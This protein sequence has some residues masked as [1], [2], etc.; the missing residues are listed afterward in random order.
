MLLP[1]TSVR[2]KSAPTTNTNIPPSVK[3][4]RKPKPSKL[5]LRSST[6]GL[7]FTGWMV[8]DMVAVL[9]K[10]SPSN[11]CSCT[12]RFPTAGSSAVFPNSSSD[13]TLV[14]VLTE[15]LP[16]ILINCAEANN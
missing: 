13:N 16:V 1:S 8:M 5:V 6:G 14:Y 4:V 12:I 15:A 11:T 7:S 9:L 2:D 10:D 3:V